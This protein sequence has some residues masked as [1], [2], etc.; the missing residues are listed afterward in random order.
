MRQVYS[1]PRPV[2]SNSAARKPSIDSFCLI[3]CNFQSARSCKKHS[4]SPLNSSASP[5]PL[6][7][8]DFSVQ[9]W[10]QEVPHQALQ[11]SNS[12]VSSSPAENA[13]AVDVSG[14]LDFSSFQPY[15]LPGNDFTNILGTDF[16]FD[17]IATMH[18]DFGAGLMSQV[19]QPVGGSTERI[20]PPSHPAGIE[21][22][23][24]SAS[25]TFSGV[26]ASGVPSYGVFSFTPTTNEAASDK[27]SPKGQKKRSP[28]NMFDGT[29]TS[30]SSNSYSE[31]VDRD[32]KRQRNTE[33]ARR[34]RQRKVDRTT[35]LEEALAVMTKERDELRLKLARSEAEVDVFKGMVGKRS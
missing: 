18:T 14:D 5:R 34:Y 27:T 15:Y 20:L 3:S 8:A 11:A 26:D 28:D 32:H 1:Q 9:E 7:E 30:P 31:T 4:I 22:S 12:W 19:W 16:L 2:Y 33:A 21:S 24:E 10:V 13:T 29:P 23:I 35:E 6:D 25:P 17:D